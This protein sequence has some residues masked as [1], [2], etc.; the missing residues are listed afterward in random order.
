MRHF[1][2]WWVISRVLCIQSIAQYGMQIYDMGVVAIVEQCHHDQESISVGSGEIWEGEYDGWW[3]TAMSGASPVILFCSNCKLLFLLTG[4][5]L[6]SCS[7][8]PWV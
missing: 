5:Y 6:A 4:Y 7:C 2:S 1:D 8:F 3:T